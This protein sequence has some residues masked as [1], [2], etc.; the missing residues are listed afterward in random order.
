MD[1]AKFDLSASQHFCRPFNTF[2]VFLNFSDLLQP[3][4]LKM[5]QNGKMQDKSRKIHKK[6]GES[7]DSA[8]KSEK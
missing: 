5:L 7:R 8:R 3:R 2:V 1:I 4:P 6:S